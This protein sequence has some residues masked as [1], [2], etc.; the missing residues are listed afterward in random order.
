MEGSDAHPKWY[1]RVCYVV[2]ATLIPATPEAGAIGVDR[3]VGQCTDSNGKVCEM[4]NTNRT[5][6]KLNRYRRKMDRQ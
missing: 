6:A 3:N 4:P 5:D 1:A 2:P